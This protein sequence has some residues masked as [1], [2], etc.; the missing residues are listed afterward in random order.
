[1]INAIITNMLINGNNTKTHD[2]LV[3][4][5]LHKKCNIAVQPTI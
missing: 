2:I 1:M 5:F 4:P 3:Y